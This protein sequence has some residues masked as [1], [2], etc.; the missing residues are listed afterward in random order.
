MRLS[1]TVSLGDTVLDDAVIQVGD[2]VRIGEHP[3]AAVSF[4]GLDL[5][6][7]R[8]GDGVR[9]RGVYLGEGEV[10]EFE[11]GELH[12]RVELLP[13]VY[14]PFP[15]TVPIDAGLP[16]ILGSIIL[17]MLTS[18]AAQITLERK[19]DVSVGVAR[20]VEALLLPPDL[21]V[22]TEP[23]PAIRARSSQDEPWSAPVRYVEHT[24]DR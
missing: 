1:V 16:V 13:D 7:C 23:S 3:D 2:G 4:P 18:Q 22:L 12:V 17:L 6:M 20:A 21:R 9:I 19:A 8:D 15:V 14:R 5:S 10:R 11:A 24:D